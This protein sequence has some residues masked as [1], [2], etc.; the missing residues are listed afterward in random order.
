V[1]THILI[2]GGG[3]VN[4]APCKLP[5]RFLQSITSNSMVCRLAWL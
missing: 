2:L 5:G 1:L 4:Q 3:S